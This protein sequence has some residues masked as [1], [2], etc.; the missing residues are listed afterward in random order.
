[1]GDKYTHRLNSEK[2]HIKS[3]P[4]KKISNQESTKYNQNTFGLSVDRNINNL[5]ETNCIFLNLFLRCLNQNYDI[6]LTV[7]NCPISKINAYEKKIQFKWLFFRCCYYY[8]CLYAQKRCVSTTVSDIVLYFCFYSGH[9]S[10][11]RQQHSSAEREAA[12]AV[13]HIFSNRTINKKIKKIPNE[14]KKKKRK[15]KSCAK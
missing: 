10:S 12:A 7:E 5:A 4:K 15:I 1:M 3:I 13:T 8:Y 9:F 11:C 2:V 14:S 6:Q